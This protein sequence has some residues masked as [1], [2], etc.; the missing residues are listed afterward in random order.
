MEI[1]LA[2]SPNESIKNISKYI[3]QK[4]HRGK[5][6]ETTALKMINRQSPFDWF[7]FDHFVCAC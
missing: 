7:D 1:F 6:K 4:T 5:E 3:M 2:H